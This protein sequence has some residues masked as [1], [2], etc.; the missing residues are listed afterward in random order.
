MKDLLER[1]WMKTISL[2]LVAILVGGDALNAVSFAQEVSSGERRLALIVVP[3]KGKDDVVTAHLTK[4]ILLGTMERL[5]LL[6]V[7]RSGTAYVEDISALQVAAQK[8]EEGKK[9]LQAQKWEDALTAYMTAKNAME[10][11][12][13]FADRRLF[14]R[15]YK[16][17]GVALSS[18]KRGEEARRPM[19]LSYLAYPDQEPAS[20]AFSPEARALF[21]Q[22]LEEIKGAPLGGISVEASIE[23]AE[24]FVDGE[25]R[26]FTPI[27]IAGL[28]EGEHW[29]SVISDGYTAY[30]DF[31]EVKAGAQTPVVVPLESMPQEKG[32]R[33][34][35]G[36]MEKAM[37]KGRDIEESC[38]GLMALTQTTDVLYLRISSKL[39]A[40]GV[41][42]AYCGRTFA[43]I[44]TELQKDA[45]LVQALQGF[46][47]NQLAVSLPSET[48]M[49][50][51]DPPELALPGAPAGEAIA[52]G[53][54]LIIDPN[55][56]IFKETARVRKE[57]GIVSKWW[58]WTA[59]GV[60]AGGIVATGVVL[61]RKSGGGGE[62][63]GEIRIYLNQVK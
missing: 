10:K 37:Q 1:R 31:I 43:M 16:G 4:G 14:A 23:K 59:I 41:S 6:N 42:G 29:I 3:A 7:R 50:P 21:A 33:A 34:K 22:V 32:V 57:K 20:Y 44:D 30:S 26:G 13:A 24:V 5:A 8:V 47:A 52:Q 38:R 39:N 19:R 51:I 56:P 9:A 58:F 35:M 15:V 40:I 60:V 27:K 18:L 12:M 53:E 2:L 54:E 61:A 63:T 36:D 11:A 46:L 17:L 25:F 28:V 48:A 45:S 62:T 49:G 55:S